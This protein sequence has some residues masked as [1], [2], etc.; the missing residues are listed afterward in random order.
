MVKLYSTNCPKCKVVELKLKQ[1]NIDFELI[2]DTDKVVEIG[3]K[4][5]IMSAP[6]L[7]VDGKYLD[8]TSA[9]KY[10]NEII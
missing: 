10:I 1:K 2:T 9:V 8:F 4:N 6:I 7:E 5:N 3:R